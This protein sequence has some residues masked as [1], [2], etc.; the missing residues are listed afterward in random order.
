ML[1]KNS[2]DV[3]GAFAMACALLSSLLAGMGSQ[4]TVANPM[5]V[6]AMVAALVLLSAICSIIVFLLFPT[7]INWIPLPALA[8][9]LLGCLEMTLRLIFRIRLSDWF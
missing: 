4:V 2:K 8:I 6:L 7:S 3:I 5:Y 9:G 1:S